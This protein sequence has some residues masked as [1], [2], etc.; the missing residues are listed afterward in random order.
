MGFMIISFFGHS[1]FYQNTTDT[2]TILNKLENLYVGYI[3]LRLNLAT[4]DNEKI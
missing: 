1:D 3:P 4:Q 2:E